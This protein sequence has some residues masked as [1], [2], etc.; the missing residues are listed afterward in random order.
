MLWL[1]GIET[2]SPVSRRHTERLA[3]AAIAASAGTVSDSI[4]AVVG[5][6]N[7]LYKLEL[8][9]PR[10]LRR[11]LDVVEIAT[12]RADLLVESPPAVRVL[13]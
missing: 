13:G 12:R 2:R 10:G 9:K 7:E 11:T 6:I 3:E 1:I 8:I 4:T 5:T